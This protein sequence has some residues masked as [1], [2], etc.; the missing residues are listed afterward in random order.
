MTDDLMTRARQ[1]LAN[2]DAERLA[3][4]ARQIAAADED[5]RL[6]EEAQRRRDQ[7]LADA[8]AA[9]AADGVNLTS[10]ARK[11]DAAVAALMDLIR[12]ADSR[13]AEIR[14]RAAALLAAGCSEHVFSWGD[15]IEIGDDRWTVIDAEPAELAARALALAA[16]DSLSV[17]GANIV[18]LLAPASGPLQRLTAV[19]R[20][21]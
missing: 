4:K 20:A 1:A 12:S 10:L 18:N 14:S 3:D 11:F 8:V 9:L 2:E 15:A 6:A 17:H 16:G 5:A 13:N 21:R 19:E 7:A